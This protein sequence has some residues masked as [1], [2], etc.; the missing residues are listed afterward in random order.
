VAEQLGC[1]LQL[2]L[3]WD[4][5]G[6]K[7]SFLTNYPLFFSQSIPLHPY[8]KERLWVW[9]L[10]NVFLMAENVFLLMEY[11]LPCGFSHF[12]KAQIMSLYSEGVDGAYRLQMHL[13]IVM[14]IRK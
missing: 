14:P 3:I 4:F 6:E 5:S 8:F 13:I 7:F 11:R 9:E 1:K 12:S 2:Y 10:R